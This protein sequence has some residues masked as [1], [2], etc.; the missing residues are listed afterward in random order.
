[1]TKYIII[2]KI[3]YINKNIILYHYSTVLYPSIMNLS[4]VYV[5]IPLHEIQYWST[6]M[7]KSKISNYR[8]SST[9]K[10]ID[11]LS[12]SNSKLNIVRI[13]LGYTKE[14]SQTVTL[15]EANDDMN[16]ML[17]NM[18]SKPTVFADKVGHIIKREHTP[19]RGVHFHT[20]IIYDGQKVREDITKGEQIG[21]YWREQ[22]TDGKGT[23]HNCNR[24]DYKDK[25]I[26][27]LDYKDTDKRKILDEEVLP[28]L[29]KEEQGID[30]IKSSKKARAFTRGIAPKKKDN[31]GRPREK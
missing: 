8:L 31:R 15:E 23:F 22:I 29:C 2:N 12:S 10:Y 14:H 20:V 27:M 24:N 17:N 19:D 7:S 21:D 18:R 30:N 16:R 25:G 3:I 28:Y 6:Y 9:K 11:D 1:M 13:D 5:Y 26:G 4:F